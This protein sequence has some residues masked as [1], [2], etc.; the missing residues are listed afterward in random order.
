MYILEE[1]EVI[2]AAVAVTMSQP[3]DYPSIGCMKQCDLGFGE[4][5]TFM[6]II[7]DGRI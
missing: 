4:N 1:N 2:L 5:K 7:Q 6:Q 3:E